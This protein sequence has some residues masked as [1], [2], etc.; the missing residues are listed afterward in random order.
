MF[1]FFFF[2]VFS[3]KSRRYTGPKV[4]MSVNENQKNSVVGCTVKVDHDYTDSV[5]NRDS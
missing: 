4:F 3:T 1:L 2:N 5:H